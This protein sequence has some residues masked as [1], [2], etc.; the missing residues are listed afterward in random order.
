MRIPTFYN[1]ARYRLWQASHAPYFALTN[2]TALWRFWN[3]DQFNA[4]KKYHSTLPSASQHILQT[5]E[6][7][8][9]ASTHLNDFF[10]RR[11]PTFSLENLQSIAQKEID[12]GAKQRDGKKFLH[13]FFRSDK[14]LVD[15]THPFMQLALHPSFLEI[16]SAYFQTFA[17]LGPVT[18]GITLTVG[19]SGVREAS[20]RWH[21]DPGVNKICK[22]F[23]YLSDV[24]EGAGPFTYIKGTQ[25]RG[26]FSH[27]APHKYFGEGSYYPK[28]RVIQ[29]ACTNKK[30]AEQIV[31]MVG[32]A[33]TIIFA[34]TLGLHRGGSAHQKERHMLTLNYDPLPRQESL[35]RRFL[36]P[37]DIKTLPQ[38]VAEAFSPLGSTKSSTENVDMMN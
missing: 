20:Q 31:P 21:R 15:A 17:R 2:T 22:I 7:N 28:D 1:I 32:K 4:Y 11:H 35:L 27:V 29:S 14:D 12:R 9:I 23:V 16:V 19:D 33:G 8:G 3:R 25:P 6:E 24:N 38:I 13:F 30:V 36:N 26:K 34:N 5:L 10:P 18:G 37:P